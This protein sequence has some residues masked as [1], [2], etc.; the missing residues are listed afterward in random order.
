M[1]C[2]L[3]PTFERLAAEAA[4]SSA[5][6]LRAMV[7]VFPEDP[8]ARGLA[9]QFMIGDAL[10]VAPV[11]SEGA[12]SRAVYL[13]EGRWFDAWTGE[14]LAG[15]ATVTRAAP[16]G[17]IPAFWRGADDDTLRTAQSKLSFA[18]CRPAL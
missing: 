17:T 12:T 16:L 10:L 2:A 8:K 11:L 4:V 9:D 7:L 15:G 5:P 18:D 13:P 3:R 6:L 1:H 14:E